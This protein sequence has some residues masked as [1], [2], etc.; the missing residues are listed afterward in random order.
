M[1]GFTDFFK[2]IFHKNNTPILQPLP[3]DYLQTLTENYASV[4]IEDDFEQ[5]LQSNPS[6]ENIPVA[7]KSK[8]FADYVQKLSVEEKQ[9]KL[10]EAYTEIAASL[11]YFKDEFIAMDTQRFNSA[12][13]GFIQF[14]GISNYLAAFGNEDNIYP[15]DTLRVC[16][17]TVPALSEVIDTIDLNFAYSS[18]MENSDINKMVIEKFDASC[19]KNRDNLSKENL[20]TLYYHI[21][22][23]YDK[24]TNGEKDKNNYL[25]KALA[26][27]EDP[28][29]IDNLYN[30]LPDNYEPK[31]YLARKAISHALKNP[32]TAYNPDKWRLNKVWAQTYELGRIVGPKNQTD[33]N[34]FRSHN[35][36]A[37]QHYLMAAW[38]APSE[39]V[40][41]L[42][43][44]IS[45]VGNNETPKELIDF[46][47]NKHN[48]TKFRHNEDAIAFY[49]MTNLSG[50]KTVN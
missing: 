47:N 10:N 28:K 21:A 14:A 15:L 24:V 2:K 50:G 4:K 22:Y 40:P 49:I 48:K 23:A 25:L 1:S 3:V 29:M 11:Q 26:L 27:T 16:V 45:H 34:Y 42:C 13:E 12:Y 38:E 43:R 37:R 31:S 44:Q 32:E 18:M 33:K 5:S 35:K 19:Q 20:A 39:E 7:E 6:A 30:A 17:S 41:T 36:L 8:L 46:K 9:A